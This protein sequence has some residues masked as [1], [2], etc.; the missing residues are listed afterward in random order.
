MRYYDYENAMQMWLRG[1]DIGR[2]TWNIDE[3]PL[4]T[5]WEN[6]DE[7]DEVAD[8]YIIYAEE[9]NELEYL[10]DKNEEL[11]NEIYFL[12]EHIKMLNKYIDKLIEKKE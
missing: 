6:L 4:E 11:K 2:A 3:V 10:K 12:E 5:F 8:D 1:T 9:E 7:E